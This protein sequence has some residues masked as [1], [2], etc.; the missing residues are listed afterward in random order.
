MKKKTQS[1][2]EK[3]KSTFTNYSRVLMMILFT[4]LVLFIGFERVLKPRFTAYQVNRE[5][6]HNLKKLDLKLEQVM[7]SSQE[8]YD[9]TSF[10]EVYY[11]YLIGQDL[12]GDISVFNEAG[13]VL[14]LT[15]PSD[16][17]SFLKRTYNHLVLENIE[18]SV[19]G[20]HS[21]SMKRTEDANDYNDLVY[22][23]KVQRTDGSSIYVV[24][25]LDSNQM[26]QYGLESHGHPIIITDTHN[27]ILTSGFN[28]LASEYNRFNVSN[29]ETVQIENRHYKVSV[30][31]YDNPNLKV[32]VL[33]YSESLPSFIGYIFVTLILVMLIHQYVSS[34]VA[35]RIGRQASKSISSLQEVIDKVAQ[36]EFGITVDL[37]T[38]DEFEGLATAFN[39]MSQDLESST[40]RNKLLLELQKAAEIKQLEAQFNPHFLYNSLETI[41]YLIAANPKLA[42]SLILKNTQLLRY[43]IQSQNELVP[44]KEDFK[45]IMLYL[46]IHQI[47]L[48][49]A[50][51]ISI[52]IEDQVYEEML[53]RLLLQPLIENSIKHGYRHQDTLSIKIKGK[54][55]GSNV[56]I[57]VQDDGSGMDEETLKLFQNHHL[58]R[59]NS[60]VQYGLYSIHHRLSLIYKDQ[61]SVII[62]SDQNG[63]LI[64]LTMPR[65]TSHV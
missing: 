43:S 21:S 18:T 2:E 57:S 40:N 28:T 26:N 27:N 59:L 39:T 15:N 41:R 52:D 36:G 61:A 14:F 30:T 5:V 13:E 4:V 38:Q 7:K 33:T 44:F 1:F 16:Q 24:I 8:I 46:E 56:V 37:D 11:K 48:E 29:L 51:E 35:S 22:G 58:A 53:P 23:E 25:Y 12:K 3:I 55:E 45:Y 34:K 6:L 54:I 63:T 42:E 19:D 65:R 17:G 9:N 60:G 20:K 10:Y 31:Q 47:R 62:E 32:H 50:L 64:S 49:E